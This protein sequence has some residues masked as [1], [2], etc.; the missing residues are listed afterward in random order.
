MPLVDGTRAIPDAMA[1]EGVERYI[2]IATPSLRDPR[3]TPSPL[4]RIVPFIGPHSYPAR[5]AN[6]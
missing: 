2:A 6:S 1:A 4:G 3:D 5:T